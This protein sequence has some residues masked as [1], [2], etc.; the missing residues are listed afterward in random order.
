[1]KKIILI[2]ALIISAGVKAQDDKT[3]TL[4][5]SGQGKT[6]EEAKQIALRSAIEQA[7]GAFISSKTEILNDS[8]VKNEIVSVS[9]GNIQKFEIISEVQ[10]PGGAFATTLSA[11]V[12]VSKLTS[13]CESKGVVI[14]FKGGLFAA[15]LKQQ[16]LNEKSEIITVI[17]LCDVSWKLLSKA[18]E[19]EIKVGETPLLIDK[20]NQ[21]YSLSML[22]S[23]KSNSNKKLFY[24]Y[25]KKNLQSISISEKELELY[26]ASNIPFY[27]FYF[28]GVLSDGEAE[29]LH[30]INLRSDKS[31]QAIK[32]LLIKSNKFYFDF[33]ITTNIDTFYLNSS[34]NK[35]T[36][37]EDNGFYR[38]EY[39]LNKFFI[40]V[41]GLPANLSINEMRQKAYSDQMIKI[42]KMGRSVN[43]CQYM[44]E[45]S[46]LL[47][48]KLIIAS[49]R[50]NI[51]DLFGVNLWT[52]NDNMKDCSNPY[53]SYWW[54]FGYNICPFIITN[55]DQSNFNIFIQKTYTLEEIEQIKKIEISPR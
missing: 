5:V 51:L 11:V 40:G 45:S 2:I 15:N 21:V 52:S 28:E 17:N 36:L 47:N 37:G 1:M 23:S 13:F 33:K 50:C 42:S 24:D 9:S 27:T 54:W 31:I 34:N 30:P 10:I 22:I 7:F 35:Y 32:N 14:E 43:Q 16:L 12:S 25:F 20:E 8:L 29:T 3:V 18:I 4:L 55:Y 48:F 46:P 39:R 49:E 53:A 19:Y 41:N 38:V 44:G 6:A 26:K